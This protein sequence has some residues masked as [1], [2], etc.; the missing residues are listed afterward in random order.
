MAISLPFFKKVVLYDI[1]VSYYEASS[2]IT[3]ALEAT[4]K[5]TKIMGE[6]G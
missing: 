4:F 6:G 3:K 1:S 2:M 5:K